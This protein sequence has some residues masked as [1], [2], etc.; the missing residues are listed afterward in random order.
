LTAPSRR[1]ARVIAWMAPEVKETIERTAARAGL[2]TSA[3][4]RMTL[5]AAV[6]ASED[7]HDREAEVAS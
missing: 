7:D 6:H 5:L 2:P 3:W 4:A 1:P